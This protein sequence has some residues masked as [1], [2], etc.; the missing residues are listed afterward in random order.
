M[1]QS[2]ANRRNLT[3]EV[4]DT[5]APLAVGPTYEDLERISV[6]VREVGLDRVGVLLPGELGGRDGQDRDEVLACI[7][8][9]TETLGLG[10][11]PHEILFSGRRFRQR[12]AHYRIAG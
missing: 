6:E 11:T 3:G 4:R 7:K 5:K 2:R 12:G 9:M 1:K 8:R 10:D